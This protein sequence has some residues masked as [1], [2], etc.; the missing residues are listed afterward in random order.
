MIPYDKWQDFIRRSDP[1]PFPFPL[2]DRIYEDKDK[3]FVL[4]NIENG[5]IV[6]LAIYGDGKHWFNV[7]E[8]DA[9]RLGIKKIRGSTKRNP[10]AWSRRHG[11]KVVGYIIEKDVG[12]EEE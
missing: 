1:D 7:M 8:E 2:A 12:E 4:Y 6:V 5:H 9:R 11:V 10:A 3:G